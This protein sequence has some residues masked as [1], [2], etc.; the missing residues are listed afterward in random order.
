MGF[1]DL[2]KK[3]FHLQPSTTCH[4]NLSLPKKKKKWKANHLSSRYGG[5]KVQPKISS[6]R[7]DAK[8]S[9][10]TSVRQ[11][12]LMKASSKYPFAVRSWLKYLLIK[13]SMQNPTTTI[14][15]MKVQNKVKKLPSS[16][17]SS[18]PWPHPLSTFPCAIVL[19]THNVLY[20][21]FLIESFD[22]FL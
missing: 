22:V 8:T 11:R 12:K 17:S 14:P 3:C 4:P 18:A 7:M 1:E 6:V 2:V 21:V 19:I 13:Q 20:K 16:T 5:S 9:F 15:D 10:R